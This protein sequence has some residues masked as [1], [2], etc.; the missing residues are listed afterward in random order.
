MAEENLE[1]SEWCLSS[2][3]VQLGWRG[4]EGV[5]WQRGGGASVGEGPKET[6]RALRLGQDT[7]RAPGDTEFPREAASQR[8]HA[9]K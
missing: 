2:F 3:P 7:T 8:G 6:A 5:G 9:Q 4:L 1:T